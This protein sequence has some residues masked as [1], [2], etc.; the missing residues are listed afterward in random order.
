M[1]SKMSRWAMGVLAGAAGFV[2]L[3]AGCNGP[4]VVPAVETPEQ[5]LDKAQLN[6]PQANVFQHTDLEVGRRVFRFDTFGDEAFWSGVLHLQQAI[7]G[8]AHGGV[9]GGVSPSTALAVGLKVDV[10]AL[11][12]GTIMALRKGKV[13]LNSP[14]T[15]LALLAKNAVVGIHSVPDGQGGLQSL[16]ITCA[17]CHSTVDDSLAPGI[18]HRLDGWPNQDLNVGAIVNLSPDL[19]AVAQLLGVDQATV[20][21][22]L[23]SWG[24]GR[25]DAELFMDGKA[26]RPDQKTAATVIPPA[27]GLAGVNLHTYN[28]WGSIPYWSC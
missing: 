2:G 8:S 17:F 15:T 21:A 28:G 20:R 10:D 1:S 12:P 5:G 13:D 3:V 7:E 6:V 4:S 24:P 11:G 9:G 22:V 14:D 25:F 16:G 19:S 18:G 27:Y 23:Q 26:F